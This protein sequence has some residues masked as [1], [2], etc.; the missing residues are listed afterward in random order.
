MRTFKGESAQFSFNKC[1]IPTHDG[2]SAKFSTNS[3]ETDNSVGQGSHTDKKEKQIFLIYKEI[4][5]G[6]VA[7]SYMTN[8]LIIY[9]DIFSH[10]LIY[11]EVLPH[12]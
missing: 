7:K 8:G 12:I 10:F 11:Y 6:S 1:P 9:G 5:N 3:H 2:A 4:Q